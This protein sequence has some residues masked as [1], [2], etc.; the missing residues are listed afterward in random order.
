MKNDGPDPCVCQTHQKEVNTGRGLKISRFHL[1]SQGDTMILSF[2][3]ILRKP[4][5]G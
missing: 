5:E 4:E 3:M 2:C 1:I